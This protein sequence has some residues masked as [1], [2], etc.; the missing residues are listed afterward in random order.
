[1]KTKFLLG[2]L[3]LGISASAY[4]DV[5]SA[6]INQSHMLLTLASFF[7]VGI[8]LAFTPC[9]LPMVPILS[10]ILVGQEQQGSQR[11]F[12][13]SLVFVLSMA[14]TYAVA[15]MLA[16][17]V[18]ST[19][20]TWMQQPW[21]IISFSMIFVLM[22]LYMFGYLN[23]SLP[24]FMQNR[25]HHVNNKLRSGSYL[26]VAVMGILSTLIASPCVTAPLISVLTF[27]SQTGSAVQ[28]GMILFVLALGMGVPLMIFGIGQ[29]ALLPKVGVW[30]D[31]VK[32]LFGVMILGMAIWML[33]RILPGYI[34]MFLTAGLVIVSAVAFGA[35]DFHAERKLSPVM[36]GASVLALVYGVFLFAG[37]ASGNENLFSPL[38][39]AYSAGTTTNQERPVSSLFT[40]VQTLPELERKVH[41]ARQAKMPVMIEF[42]AT[43]CPHCQRV[44]SDVLTDPAIRK[45][46]KNFVTLRVDLSERDPKL[47]TIMEHYKIMGVPAMVFYDK[48]GR[49]YNAESLEQGITRDG[50][51]QVLDKLG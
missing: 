2:A 14:L 24:S 40:Y 35:L 31:T 36:H 38:K 21:I 26:G 28:G 20:Q 45:S 17:Y 7:G 4:A 29:S 12:R 47:A 51:Q 50:L 30:M 18:G 46:M 32:K 44:D 33:S 25:L 37:A 9:V 19:V 3:A 27:I 22:A 39:P 23:L 10:A 1:M 48:D 13:L 42:F 49:R 41:E 43:W 15:G 11:A 34:T 16:G 5:A 6:A 8:L